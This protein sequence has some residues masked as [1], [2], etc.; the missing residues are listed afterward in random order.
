MN[1]YA[2]IVCSIC[3][4]TVLGR[5]I[6][7]SIGSGLFEEHICIKCHKQNYIWATRDELITDFEK[8]KHKIDRLINDTLLELGGVISLG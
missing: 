6:E 3:G 2:K 1:L 8:D 4:N 7:S 5:E